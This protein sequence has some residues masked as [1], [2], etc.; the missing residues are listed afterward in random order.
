MI[1]TVTVR[2]RLNLETIIRAKRGPDDDDSRTTADLFKKIRVDKEERQRFIR[3]IP[4][5]APWVNERAIENEPE[6][7]IDLEAAEVRKLKSLLK[8]WQG[9][10]VDD[11]EWKD[12]L[13]EQLYAPIA[14]PDKEA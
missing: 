9:Y 11:F 12:P 3:D 4:G 2:Q 5:G 1:L 8:E 13:A 6:I 7:I 14:T 10:S